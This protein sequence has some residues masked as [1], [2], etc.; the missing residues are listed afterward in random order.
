MGI[1]KV[2]VFCGSRAGARPAYMDAARAFGT[3][4]GQAGLSLVYGGARVGLMGAVADA[5][6]AAGAEVIGI[7]PDDFDQVEV[8]HRGLTRLETTDGMLSRKARMVELSDAF[9]ALP[10]GGGT[11]D[12]LFEVFTFAQLG[13]HR[14]PIALYR[15]A[16]YWDALESWVDHAIAEG[17]IDADQRQLLRAGDDPASVLTALGL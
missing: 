13:F 12:E 9:V 4:L 11:L 1:H 10:G 7:I 15:V 17:F 14:K 5:A 6:L 16:G 3:A 2:C 8:A